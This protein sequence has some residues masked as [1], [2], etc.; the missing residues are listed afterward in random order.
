MLKVCHVYKYFDDYCVN[1][2]ISLDLKQGEIFGL[3][4]PNG[5]GK[6]TLMRMLATVTTPD[7]GEILIKGE[8]LG[9]KHVPLIG[10][11]PEERGLYRKMSVVDQLLYFAELK[12][13]GR[14]HAKDNVRKWLHRLDIVHWADKKMEELSKGMAQ[15]IQF[16]ST[17]LHEPEFLILDEPFSG[18]DPVN[19]DMVKDLIIEL[20]ETGT[21]ILF[22]THRMDNV[23]ELCDRLAII[24]EG[25]KVLDG[26]IDEVRREHFKF[27]YDLSFTDV[28]TIPEY[29]KHRKLEVVSPHTYRIT[30]E[31][32]EPFNALLDWAYGTQ[33]L[34]A[35]GE[36]LPTMHEI[37]VN[38]VSNK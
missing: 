26:S 34:K 3:L 30:L 16:I 23:E 20:K 19:A 4:G 5:A 21:T 14:S 33:K 1:N 28:V 31:E 27:E 29:F 18:F 36:Y 24:H 13:L 25:K 6:T 32:D 17:I 38:K 7:R 22:S 9:P 11:M 2:D 15:K 37:F 12:G 8:N 35:F 10:Y